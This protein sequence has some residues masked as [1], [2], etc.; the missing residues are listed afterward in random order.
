MIDSTAYWLQSFFFDRPQVSPFKS[1]VKALTRVNIRAS[2]HSG[3]GIPSLLVMVL[4][5]GFV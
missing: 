4:M 5:C 3:C 2:T 1:E